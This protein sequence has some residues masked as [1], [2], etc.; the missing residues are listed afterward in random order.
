MSFVEDEMKT[1]EKAETFTEG[2]KTFII[3]ILMELSISFS[4]GF[5]PITQ[6]FINGEHGFIFML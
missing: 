4:L 1:K 5:N 3:F 2:K 6:K